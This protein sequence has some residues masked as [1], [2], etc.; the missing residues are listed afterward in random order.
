MGETECVYVCV[1]SLLSPGGRGKTCSLCV[2][3]CVPVHLFLLAGL[4]LPQCMY[5]HVSIHYPPPLHCLEFRIVQSC[6][7]DYC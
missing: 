4:N 5:V 1:L 2:W 3:M 7:T 6:V